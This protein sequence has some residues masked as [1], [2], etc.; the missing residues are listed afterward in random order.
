MNTDGSC[1]STVLPDDKETQLASN[2]QDFLHHQLKI[3]S[4][5]IWNRAPTA[6]SGDMHLPEVP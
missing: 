6:T 1:E 4:H 5:A 3:L 2:N